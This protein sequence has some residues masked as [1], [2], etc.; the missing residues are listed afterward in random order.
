MECRMFGVRAEGLPAARLRERAE[1]IA[2]IAA[3]RVS[4]G[5]APAVRF[6]PVPGR[7]DG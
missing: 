1:H 6:Q 5:T 7:H 4:P 2:M 3:V